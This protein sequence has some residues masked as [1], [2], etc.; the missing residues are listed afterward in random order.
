QLIL[1]KYNQRRAA[2]QTM[3]EFAAQVVNKT[4]LNSKALYEILSMVEKAKYSKLQL[5]D[6]DLTQS[7]AGFKLLYN[8]LTGEEFQGG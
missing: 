1:R 3:R 6:S 2:Y 8:Q 7:I 5:T 4:D